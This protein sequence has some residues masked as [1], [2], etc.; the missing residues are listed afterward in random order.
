MRHMDI[1]RAEMGTA[2]VAGAAANPRIMEYF[3][4]CGGDWAKD[5]SVPWC[6]GFVGW[7]MTRAGHDLPKEPLRA[8]AWAEWG[9]PLAAFEPGCVVVLS[10]GSDP[11]SGHVTLGDSETATHIMGLGGNQGDRVSIVAYPKTGVI[12]WRRVP[13]VAAP[14]A[15]AGPVAAAVKGSQTIRNAAY[16]GSALIGLAVENGAGVASDAVEGLKGILGHDTTLHTFL[17]SAKGEMG[18]LFI[19]IALAT[20]I[21]VVIRRLDAAQKGKIG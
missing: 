19:A 14:A 17:S 12:A 6:G 15:P 1:A 8:R 10:R 21:G 7:V 5:D 2:E 18:W 11:A 3:R 9:E 20:L 4:T 16:G 13:G